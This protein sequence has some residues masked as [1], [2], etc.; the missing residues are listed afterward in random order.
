[1]TKT[2]SGLL[3]AIASTAPVTTAFV[4][5]PPHRLPT[6]TSPLSPPPTLLFSSTTPETTTTAT[7]VEDGSTIEPTVEL[8]E[9]WAREYLAAVGKAEQGAGY[10][11]ITHWFDEDY[12]Q[13]GPDIGPLNKADF[14]YA[15]STY[16]KKGLDLYKLSPD[17]TASL[18]GFH[19]DPHNPWRVWFTLRYIGTHT[20]T[21]TFPN[22]EVEIRPKEGNNK[23]YGG[24]EMYSFWFT[25]QKQIKWQTLGFVGDRYTGTNGGYGGLLGL[26][27]G[28]G[29]PRVALDLFSPV[30]KIQTWLSQFDGFG[31]ES[32][33]RTRSKSSELPQ[34][35]KDRAKSGMNLN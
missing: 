16:K 29:I 33:P 22:S 5:P 25:P 17:L 9:Q 34:W 15:L 23:I 26:L 24:P 3:L 20:G 7:T 27:V 21:I 19:V 1:M 31:D 14:I 35:W 13:T 32:A 12:V 30:I 2:F 28:F 18:D 6:S 11:E 10:E 4:T 8:L